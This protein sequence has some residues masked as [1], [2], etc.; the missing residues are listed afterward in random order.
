LVIKPNFANDGRWVKKVAI[1]D[2]NKKVKQFQY[3]VSLG[4]DM[5]VQELSTQYKTE[6]GEQVGVVVVGDNVTHAVLKKPKPDSFLVHLSWGGDQTLYQPTEEKIGFTKQVV[7]VTGQRFGHF[8]L[9]ARVDMSRDN[10]NELD[11]MEQTADCPGLYFFMC[12]RRG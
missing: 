2:F 8:P 12:I 6:Q 10:S 3:L 5:L 4:H 9:R 11:L 1:S 7:R